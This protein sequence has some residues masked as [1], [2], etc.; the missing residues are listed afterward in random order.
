MS[1]DATRLTESVKTLRYH[2]KWVEYGLI[3]EE[4]FCLQY[5]RFLASDDKNTEH[6]RYAAFQSLLAK[7]EQLTD[8]EL[9]RYVELAR[10][11]E[12]QFMSTAALIDLIHWPGLATEQFERLRI[13]PKLDDPI[14]HKAH[15]RRA[16]S[17]ELSR[18]P[19]LT[20]AQFEVIFSSGDSAVQRDLVERRDLSITQLRKLREGGANRAIRNIAKQALQRRTV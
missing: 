16:L 6:Y 20:E 15:R 18:A 14:L 17:R 12:D 11:D 9:E 7:S 10:L 5:A 8:E 19:A 4:F 2:P 3:A 1:E 13:H